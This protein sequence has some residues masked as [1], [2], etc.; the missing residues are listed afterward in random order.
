MQSNVPRKPA[1]FQ[2]AYRPFG[3]ATRRRPVAA[4]AAILIVLVVGSAMI[5]PEEI[6]NRVAPPATVLSGIGAGNLSPDGQAYADGLRPFVDVL[7]GEGLALA[8]LGQE[9]SRNIVELSVRMD[10]YRTAA[11]DIEQYIQE[12]STPTALAG[13][14]TELRQRIDESLAAID[15]SITAIRAFDWDALGR[16]VEDFSK[17]VDS[18]ARLAGTPTPA[19]D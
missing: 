14:V 1:K 2:R 6:G 17:A 3:F 10:R 8:K 13:Y 19:V 9:R 12:H 16:T 15:A 18:I 5:A 7:V 4:I 11:H